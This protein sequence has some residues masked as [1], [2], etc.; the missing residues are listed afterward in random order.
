MTNGNRPSFAMSDAASAVVG[1]TYGGKMEVVLSPNNDLFIFTGV[2]ADIIEREGDRIRIVKM[3]NGNPL[4]T[5]RVFTDKI[6]QDSKLSDIDIIAEANYR[7]THVSNLT[8]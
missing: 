7:L 2:D 8:A 4:P 3:M 6:W 5:P 1:S